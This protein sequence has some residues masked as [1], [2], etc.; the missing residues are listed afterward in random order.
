MR[1]VPEPEN[2]QQLIADCADIPPSLEAHPVVIMP[3]TAPRWEVDD[4]T[5]A[6]V[7]DLDDYV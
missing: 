6:Q 3:R 2:L 5:R 4:A 1:V 7:E